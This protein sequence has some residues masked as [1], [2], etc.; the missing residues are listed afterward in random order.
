MAYTTINKSTDYFN[1]VLYVGNGTAIGSGGKTVTGV[2]FQPDW[3]WGKARSGTDAVDNHVLTDAV[4]G[5]TKYLK[6]NTTSSE[7]TD[8]E[9][10][11]SF[12]NDGF[13]LGSNGQMNRNG[14]NCVAW[15]WKAGGAGSANTDGSISSTVSAN[16]TSGFSIVTFTGNSGT[17]GH[18]LGVKPNFIVVKS[19]QTGGSNNWVVTHSALGT[20]MNDNYIIL[21]LTDAA[22][23]G[24]NTWGGEPTT[25]TFTVS[26]GVAANDNNVAYCFA[27]KKGFSKFSSF[28][29]NGNAD[30]T[31]IYTGFKPAMVICKKSS[32]SGTNWGIIDNKRA[33]SFNVISAMLNPNSNGT[34]GA[35]NNCDFVS[36][37]F[38]WR[39]SDAN[40][41]ASGDTYIY[42]AFAEAPLVGS[43]NVPCTAR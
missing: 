5:A 36:N 3:V 8:T 35:N 40:S 13:T 14:N 26:S 7:T 25:T 41:N 16:T 31:F 1:S 28:V 23:S 27:E 2:G 29:G 22:G 24:S 18:G 43:N 37:G 38:K 30:G 39:S 20:N 17:V 10:L 32:A 15:N 42:M 19:R 6:S 33:N 4:R 11:T 34:E 21:N 12:T 9:T